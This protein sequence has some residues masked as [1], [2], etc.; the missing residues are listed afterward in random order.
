MD[1]D[2]E[3]EGDADGDYEDGMQ[4]GDEEV[5]A[6]QEEVQAVDDDDN[7]DVV[8][9]G[10]LIF[11]PKIDKN[12]SM[13]LRSNKY[14]YMV[15][16]TKVQSKCDFVLKDDEEEADTE[17]VSQDANQTQQ[18]VPTGSNLLLRNIRMPS[19]CFSHCFC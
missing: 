11:I 16:S 4:E 6:G 12:Y 17:M 1:A 9:V 10:E 5:E 13:T 15:Q 3:I 7:D 18:D 19:I 8:I 2:A 14:F